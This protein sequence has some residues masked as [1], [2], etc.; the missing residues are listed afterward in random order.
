MSRCLFLSQYEVAPPPVALSGATA[1]LPKGK[2]P[3][4]CDTVQQQQQRLAHGADNKL[5]F[6]DLPT[7]GDP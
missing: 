7:S 2:S 6:T 1:F 4:G 5:V 3:G